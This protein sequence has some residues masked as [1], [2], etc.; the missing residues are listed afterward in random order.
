M[1]SKVCG[2]LAGFGVGASLRVVRAD[3]TA[4]PSGSMAYGSSPSLV[5]EVF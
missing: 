3:L 5:F 2:V 1:G 4:S